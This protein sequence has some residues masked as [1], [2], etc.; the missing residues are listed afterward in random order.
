M[1]TIPE[2]LRLSSY[3]YQLPP[4]L[5]AERPEQKRDECRLLIY[6]KSTGEIL[7]DQ[8]KNIGDYLP[9]E[10]CLVRNQSKV[11]PCRLKGHKASGA[12]SEVF[13]LGPFGGHSTQRV[14]IKSSSKKHLGD[15][16]IFNEG[17]KGTIS[18]VT[19]DGTFQMTFNLEGKAFENF[20]ENQA[21]V[22][23]PPYIRGGESDQQ[24][25]EDYQTI[26]AKEPGSV[27]APTA[28]LHFTEEL[29]KKLLGKGISL[30]H[31]T[32]HVGLG[33]F[34]PV[35]EE[36]IR[37]HQMHTE[38]FHVEQED[39]E[40]IRKA[41]VRIAVG[42][43]SLR[44]LESIY[45]QGRF[46]LDEEKSETGIF[47]FPGRTIH[48]IQGLIT[49]FHLPKSSLLML[50]SAYIGRTETLRIYREAVQKE[51]RFYSYGDSMLLI[52]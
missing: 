24:D 38:S 15:E 32:L 2:D 17:L 10:S 28:G 45:D 21:Q 30:A 27:A 52:E 25:K 46:T 23:I 51:Y 8:F 41:P 22:P 7:H 4:E 18:Q 14:L 40:R 33:T 12:K 13:I 42:T 20:L 16:Y 43:T 31:V 11:V 47:L 49:N 3:D 1:K 5:I 35:K 44:V 26:Y 36:D 50:I 37:K 9:Q 6:I 19:G 34:S 39:L 29:E 48:S